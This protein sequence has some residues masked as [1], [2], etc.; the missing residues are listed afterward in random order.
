MSS[1]S[2]ASLAAKEQE[3]DQIGTE[4]QLLRAV[5]DQHGGVV[6]NID[7][8]MDTW[9]FASMLDCS[10]TRWKELGKK[11]VWIKLPIEH[12][13]LVAV[14][15]K[16]G[17]TYHHA[18][19]D[20]V[21]LVNWISN[22]PNTIPPNASH[23][24]GIGAF[25]M[26]TNGEGEDIC[27]A[28]IREVKEETGIDTEFVEV[29]AFRQSH[30]TFFQKS[31]LFF[32]CLLQPYSFNIQRQASEIAA[33][34][35]MPIKDYVAQPFVR[36]NELFDLLTKIWL[37]KVDKNYTGFSTT[38]AKTSKSKKSYLYFN[39]NDAGFL[40]PPKSINGQS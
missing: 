32:A 33:A 17:F 34:Q 19:P 28:A 9:V 7:E 16:A 2:S 20:Y 27:T 31:D 5:E 13:N 37:S 11:G 21:M 10:L 38:L 4:F 8:T 14:A 36:E 12:S 29:L 26:N 3:M 18:E 35:W 15:V 30:Q 40:L 25:V 1:V 24:V 22:A 39:K 6:V 23:R